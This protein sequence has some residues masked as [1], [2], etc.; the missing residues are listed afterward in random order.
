MKKARESVTSCVIAVFFFFFFVS[1]KRGPGQPVQIGH[2]GRNWAVSA[3]L[4]LV[5]GL[6]KRTDTDRH[7]AAEKEQ[8]YYWATNSE[9]GFTTTFLQPL[10]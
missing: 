7:E 9:H 8:I 10:P 4:P 3:D 6:S 2:Y 1:P 5:F